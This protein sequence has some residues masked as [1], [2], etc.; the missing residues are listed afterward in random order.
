M[1]KTADKT[2][3]RSFILYTQ[4][5]EQVN[6]LTNEQAGELLKRCTNMPIPVKP[7]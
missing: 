7:R 2:E 6:M 1:A 3:K 5:R 4:H